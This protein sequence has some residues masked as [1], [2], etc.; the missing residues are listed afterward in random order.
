MKIN[1]NGKNHNLENNIT[2]AKLLDNLKLD[3]DA[4]A[5]ELNMVIIPSSEYADTII[6]ENDNIEIVQFVGGG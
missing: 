4:I 6:N 3:L 1:L 5:I 2:I